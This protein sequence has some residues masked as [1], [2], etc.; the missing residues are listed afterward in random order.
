MNNDSKLNVEVFRRFTHRLPT[1]KDVT[2]GNDLPTGN[3]PSLYL[4]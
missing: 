1:P 4:S 2:E 3:L